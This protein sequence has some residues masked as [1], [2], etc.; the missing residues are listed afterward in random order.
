M[1]NI[2]DVL[3]Y[4]CKHYP[5]PDELSKARI[6]KLVYLADWEAALKTGL[7]LTG[8][9]WF[10]HNFGPYV[11]DVIEAARI[12]SR[13]DVIRTENMYREPK[14]LVRIKK[15][16]SDSK[17]ENYQEQII[18]SVIGE[19]KNYYWKDFIR[20]VYETYPIAN[21]ERY[22][23]LDLAALAKEEIMKGRAPVGVKAP[24]QR[25]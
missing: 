19:T 14:E 9:K 11:E 25:I 20:H 2:E 16:A 10:F 8:I 7:P 23:E 6:T 3:V 1:L 13:L 15:G 18:N 12:S 4:I 24:I 17:L 22:S 21:R 5:H